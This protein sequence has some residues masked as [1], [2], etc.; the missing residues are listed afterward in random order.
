MSL[1]GIQSAYYDALYGGNSSSLETMIYGPESCTSSFTTKKRVNIYQNNTFEALKETLRSTFPVCKALVGDKYFSQLATAHVHREF[2]KTPNLD[3]YGETFAQTLHDLISSHHELH[4]LPYLSDVAT[5]E[6]LLHHSYYAKDRQIFDFHA[7]SVLNGE[8]Q[9]N[10]SFKLADDICLM[11]SQYPVYDIWL[12]HQT[13]KNN[14]IKLAFNEQKQ[15]FIAISRTRFYPKAMLL[16]ESDYRLLMAIK[17]GK[18]VVKFAH[19][20]EYSTMDLA[21]LIEK[22]WVDAFIM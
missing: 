11:N 15:Y 16:K 7:F 9:N 8:E 17:K 20:L 18:S 5:L 21:G 14:L 10:V 13:Q 4:A 6:W 3:D 1:K 22:G 12:S 19:L 2:L